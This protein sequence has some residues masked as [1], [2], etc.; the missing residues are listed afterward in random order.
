MPAQPEE[1]WAQLNPRASTMGSSMEMPD[2]E[3]A[4]ESDGSDDVA[5]NAQEETNSNQEYA[6]KRILIIIERSDLEPVYTK[7]NTA[8]QKRHKQ[9][10]PNPLRRQKN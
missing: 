3:P 9:R 8:H 4:I 7:N 5:Q 1:Q 2:D 6:G 10:Q